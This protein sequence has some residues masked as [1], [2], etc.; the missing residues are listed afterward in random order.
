ML[1]ESGNSQLSCAM[2][3]WKR[4]SS[5]HASSAVAPAQRPAPERAE[6]A[7]P[8][9]SAPGPQRG[10]RL[11]SLIARFPRF[12]CGQL[13]AWGFGAG[14]RPPKECPKAQRRS[15]A[16]RPASAPSRTC[17]ACGVSCRCGPA[18][19]PQGG[20]MAGQHKGARGP[21]AVLAP[22]LICARQLAV[23]RICS[24]TIVGQQ[25]QIHGPRSTPHRITD[26]LRAGRAT[27]RWGRGNLR[28]PVPQ[29]R[30]GAAAGCGSHTASA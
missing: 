12:E 5:Q 8:A 3:A 24:H 20:V 6:T 4:S 15:I 7:G 29:R 28:G 10:L 30:A 19:G 2:H 17:G 13:A 1:S 16:N 11:L 21:T 14:A 22:L 9:P 18:W 23:K 27:G 26:C 25:M